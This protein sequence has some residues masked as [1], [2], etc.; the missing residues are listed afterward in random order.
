MSDTKEPSLEERATAL[1]LY[2][3]RLI[4]WVIRLEKATTE[5]KELRIWKSANRRQVAIGRSIERACADLPEGFDLHV[6]CEKGAGTVRLYH[7]DGEEESE[8]LYC[9][10][11]LAGQIDNAINIAC[12]KGGAA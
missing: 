12:A 7:P 8:D 10:S 2:N 6:E 4:D 11:G 5:A 3:A 9:D 1:G